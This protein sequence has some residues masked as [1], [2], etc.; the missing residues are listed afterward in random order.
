MRGIASLGNLTEKPDYILTEVVRGCI[1]KTRVENKVKEGE[2]YV[3]DDG[4]MI[5]L[6]FIYFTL[7]SEP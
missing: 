7:G 6:W 3:R 5:P 4:N 1:T 2:G